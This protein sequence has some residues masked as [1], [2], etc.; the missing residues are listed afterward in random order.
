MTEGEL[1]RLRDD[2]RLLSTRVQNMIDIQQSMSKGKLKQRD[3]QN[4]PLFG[5]IRELGY[6]VQRQLRSYFRRRKNGV[7]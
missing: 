2:L 5:S 1:R 6:S 4:D 3:W 7:Q